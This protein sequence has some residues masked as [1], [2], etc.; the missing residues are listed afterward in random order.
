MSTTYAA[1]Y[2]E[3][4][5]VETTTGAHAELVECYECGA[6]LPYPNTDMHSAF[7]DEVR[8]LQEVVGNVRTTPADGKE[9]DWGARPCGKTHHPSQGPY[10]GMILVCDRPA[11]H[12]FDEDLSDADEHSNSTLVPRTRVYWLKDDGE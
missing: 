5:A 3:G 2:T 7:H 12:E 8:R 10:K 11:G 4:F 1:T 9:T 6:L